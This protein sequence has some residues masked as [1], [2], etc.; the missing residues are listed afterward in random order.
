VSTTEW[1]AGHDNGQALYD[2]FAAAIAKAS[3][4]N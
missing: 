3:A 2:A 1:I 4:A